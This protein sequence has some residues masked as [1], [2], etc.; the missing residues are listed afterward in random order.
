MQWFPNISVMTYDSVKGLEAQNLILLDLRS[1]LE[2]K[3]TEHEIIFRKID[4]IL[5]RAQQRLFVFLQENS[6]DIY[7]IN[8]IE[9]LLKKQ[10]IPYSNYF[11]QD[12]TPLIEQ[13]GW[14]GRVAK[15]KP[16]VKSFKDSSELI[17]TATELFA[18]IGG[19]FMN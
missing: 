16:V 7:Y 4:V 17:V 19:L 3:K 5:T 11:S 2:Q 1:Y 10:C 18:V 6:S 9:N 15:L 13:D 14:S 8:D 12:K